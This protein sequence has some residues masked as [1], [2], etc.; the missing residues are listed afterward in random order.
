[1]S[2]RI[3]HCSC[4]ECGAEFDYKGSHEKFKYFMNANSYTC[5]GGHSEL[6]SPKYFVKLVSASGPT[7]IGCQL[8]A[9]I[10]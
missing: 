7:P 4:Q 8:R 6:R 1:M 5:A 3:F 10:T 9:G 2:T